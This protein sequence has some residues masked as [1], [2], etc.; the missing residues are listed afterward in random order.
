[1]AADL[2]DRSWREL[3]ARHHAVIRAQ[4]KRHRGREPDQYM[5][6]SIVPWAPY[7]FELHTQV[8]SNS[9][10]EFSFDQFMVQPALDRIALE[11]DE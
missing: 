5:M 3:V 8:T 4:L 1:M 11:A 9:V 6:E 7:V 10:A 2:G